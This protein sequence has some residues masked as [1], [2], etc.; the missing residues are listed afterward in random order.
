VS[1]LATAVAT[2]GVGCASNDRV[3]QLENRVAQLEAAKSSAASAP[4]AAA[5][6]TS[7]PGWLISGGGHDFYAVR[8]DAE[9][10]RSGHPTIVLEPRADTHG[11]YGTWMRVVD[12]AQYRGKRVRLS[13]YTKTEG[14][15]QRAD[16]WARVQAADSPPD[17][18]G[19]GGK[20]TNLPALSD[21]RHQE[22]VLDVPAEGA[23]VQY[24]VGVAG[25]GKLWVDD[26]KLEVVGNDVPA[27]SAFEGE[28][29]VGEWLMTGVGAPDFAFAAEGD[30][31]RVERKEPSSKRFVAV[32]RAVPADAFVGKTVAAALD[33]R[34]EGLDGP[35]VCILKFQ[36][37]RP[38]AY[39][40]FLGAQHKET[41]ATAPSFHCDLSASVPEGTKWILYG[42]SYR[43]GGKAWIKGGRIEAK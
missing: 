2:V 39:A 37:A 8:V 20:W 15:T 9:A 11:K 14:A 7:E 3:A 40:G 30:A 38:L 21:W 29:T 12:A 34:T 10:P 43:G 32:V 42:F 17:G 5:A 18:S 25:P 27:S 36:R 28:Q 41:P 23:Q 13:A 26:A 16:F 19:L 35:G 31:V 24:G 6:V 22:I 33:V 1:V 4:G